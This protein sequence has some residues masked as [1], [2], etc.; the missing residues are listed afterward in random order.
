MA[1]TTPAAVLNIPPE[2]LSYLETTLARAVNAVYSPPSGAPPPASPSDAVVAVAHELLRSEGQHPESNA[3][4]ARGGSGWSALLE[5]AQLKEEVAS[6]RAMQP[7]KISHVELTGYAPAETEA[8]TIATKFASTSFAMSFGGVEQFYAGLEGY[9]GPPSVDVLHA[10]SHEHSSKLPFSSHNVRNTTPELEWSYVV[11]SQVGEGV[12]GRE[13][14]AEGRSNWRLADFVRHPRCRAVGLISEE[15]IG[16]RLYTGPM[17][18]HYNGVMRNTSDNDQYVTT[19]HAINSAI[20]KLSRKQRACSVYRGVVG[21]VLPKEFWEADEQGVRGGV[22]L[23]FMSTTTKKSVAMQFAGGDEPPNGES[24]GDAAAHAAQQSMMQMMFKMQM[25]MVD[26]GADVSFLSQFPAEEEILFAPLTGLEVVS[27]P[28]VEEGVVVVELRLSCNLHDLTLQEVISKMQRS[29]LGLVDLMSDELRIANAPPAAREALG[30]LRASAALRDSAWFNTAE[31]FQRVTALVLDT[32]RSTLRSLAS[33]DSMWANEPRD[34]LAERMR[35]VAALCAREGDRASS[36]SL[37]A[38][39]MELQPLS[40]LRRDSSGITRRR[41]SLLTIQT[42]EPAERCDDA[43]KAVDLQP[44]QHGRLQVAALVLSLGVVPPWPST[45]VELVVGPTDGREPSPIE[46]SWGEPDDALLQAVCKLISPLISADR[47][48]E[49]ALVWSW[50]LRLRNHQ[51]EKAARR[52]EAADAHF[53]IGGSIFYWCDEVR[54]PSVHP[55]GA[56]DL[57]SPITRECGLT[58]ETGLIGKGTFCTP[59][60]S[61]VRFARI[62]SPD[63]SAVE[64]R[65]GHVLDWLVDECGFEPPTTILSITGSATGSA[66][67]FGEINAALSSAVVRAGRSGKVWFFSGGTDAGVMKMVGE[68]LADTRAVLLAFTT[69]NVIAGRTALQADDAAPTSFPLTGRTYAA[70]G[71][72]MEPPVA[73]TCVPLEKNHSAFVFIDDGK[74]PGP[75]WGAE[76]TMRHTIERVVGSRYGASKLQVAIGGGPP[77]LESLLHAVRDGFIAIVLK[78]TGRASDVI[79]YG[80]EAM[81]ERGGSVLREWDAPDGL[82]AAMAARF[83]KLSADASTWGAYLRNTRAILEDEEISISRGERRIFC[84]EVG[85]K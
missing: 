21:G 61:D 44:A 11:K 33:D 76:I 68:F 38:R 10:M 9:L 84:P 75:S 24:G 37:L 30:A 16:I 12:E 6:L 7:R 59:A 46:R 3:R 27:E 17:Y 25:G 83:P 14:D 62:S 5:N 39:S 49:G 36:I 47:F 2:V 34:G 65:A 67:D 4:A 58:P 50:V 23:A 18:I 69:W 45:L 55:S 54:C 51:R 78:G 56:S 35:S 70:E 20:L 72:P 80:L 31:N 1:A 71:A 32:A 28:V 15:V 29:H 22:E 79:S 52:E 82:P 26:R 42:Y 48:V 74:R 40:A 81:L 8:R 60:R 19:M 66:L 41:A 43:M 57:P 77:T 73:P 13:A 53:N 85:G 64:E 63:A